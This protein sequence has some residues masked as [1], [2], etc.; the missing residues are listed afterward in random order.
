[1]LT[2]YLQECKHKRKWDTITPGLGIIE[3]RYKLINLIHISPVLDR[4]RIVYAPRFGYILPIVKAPRMAIPQTIL[5][6]VWFLV[7]N[8]TMAIHTPPK[9]A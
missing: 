3:T 2:N 5:R 9:I 8:S 7:D 4:E 1:M 6:N